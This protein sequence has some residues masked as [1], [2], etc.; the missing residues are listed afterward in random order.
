MKQRNHLRMG[1]VV[2]AILA[3]A[4]AL[5]ASA[6]AQPA[7][8]PKAVHI[9]YMSMWDGQADVY[10]M[11]ADGSAQ[12]NL[13]H[14]KTVGQRADTEPAWSPNGQWVAFQRSFLVRSDASIGS[15]RRACGSRRRM[16]VRRSA[17]RRAPRS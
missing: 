4:F 1:V 15:R 16:S 5:S 8:G 3:T 6:G 7:G 9:A 12:F 11:N 2:I 13:T 14:D 17:R 10:A